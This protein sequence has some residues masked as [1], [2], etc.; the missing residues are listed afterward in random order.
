MTENGQASTGSLTLVRLLRRL[1]SQRGL[2]AV[3]VAL[4]IAATVT[5]VVA[6][7]VLGRATDLLFTGVIGRQLPAGITK[8]Q[9]IAEARARGDNTFAQLVSSVNVTPG[10]G[11]DLAAVGR[12]LGLSLSLYLVAAAM[13]WGQARLLNAA[14]Q[15]T[16]V[17]LRGDVEGKLHRLPL[18]YVDS[19]R[20]GELL[21][22]L[23][24]DVDAIQT[25]LVMTTSKLPTLVLT[26]AAVLVMMLTISP[27]LTLITLLT[28]PLLALVARSIVRRSKQLFVA[29]AVTIGQLNAHLE[30]AYSGLGVVQT[31]GQRDRV[32]EQFDELN[33][34][35]R[36]ASFR[37]QFLS[38]LIAPASMFIGNLG[39]VI[40]AVVGGLQMLTGHISLGGIQAFIQYARQFNQPLTEFA[41]TYNMLQ[42][43]LASAN[44]V[45]ELLDAPE[46]EA[47][48]EVSDPDAAGTVPGRVE[49]EHV[50]FGYRPDARVID[51][52][53]LAIEPG[54]T[55]AI[56]GPTGAGKSTLMNLLMRFYEVDSGRILLDGV[57]VTTMSRQQL[58]SR[59]GMVLQ[60]SWLFAGTI[61]ENIGYGCPGASREQIIEAAKAANVD[62]FV[63]SRPDGY[64]TQV[65][66]D[67]VNL[68]AGEKQLITIARALLARPQLLMLDEAT[69]SLDSR[70]ELLIQQ[71]L[72]ELRRDRT[73]F[74][75][76]HRLSTIRDADLILVMDA[77]RIV[78]HGNHDQLM[79][80]RGAYY[81]MAF[82]AQSQPAAPSESCTR[83]QRPARAARG[84][85]IRADGGDPLRPASPRLRSAQG[86]RPW[87]GSR[88]PGRHDE[89]KD[90]SRIRQGARDTLLS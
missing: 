24:N 13:A 58:R 67:G 56:V 83:P 63:R 74:V 9:A 5:G 37:A 79:A 43:G 90:V 81:A 69:S 25:A 39:F 31:F 40:V 46:L 3:A 47:D 41:A 50:N 86:A 28:V 78:E 16:M 18:A 57:D 76:A 59:I 54:S 4:A 1:A 29:Q 61:A 80:R 82:S 66:E 35:V 68:S 8:A 32:L 38:L 27:L 11:I 12:T 55:V 48:A 75:I 77:G 21:S 85:A 84:A 73:S 42:S 71:A 15:R 45:F 17:A 65:G 23:T 10:V 87:H 53:S 60:D 36:Q 20:R 7:R 51:D 62:Q 6:T 34:T 72:G 14:I 70:T 49:F 30:E 22:R 44:R 33:E 52:L 2:T 88:P 64:D 89:K 26:V 19:F